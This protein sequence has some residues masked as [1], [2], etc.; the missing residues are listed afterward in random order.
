MNGQD[1]LRYDRLVENALRGVLRDVMEEVEKNGLPG[2]HHFYITIRTGFPGV[3]LPKA[4]IERHPDEITLVLQH[5]FWDLTVDQAGFEVTLSFNQLAER[6]RI[7]FA[8]ITAFTD[9]SCKFA[10]QF[11]VEDLALDE[12]EDADFLLDEESEFDHQPTKSEER[13]QIVSLDAFRK[14]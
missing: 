1:L 12:D 10:L 11:Q 6:C 7:P 13:G 2:D 8:A 4:M 3:R 5:Q 14:K 9:P